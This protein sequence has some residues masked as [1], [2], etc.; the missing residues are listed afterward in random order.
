M[1]KVKNAEN[2]KILRCMLEERWLEILNRV[3]IE[4]SIQDAA[5]RNWLQ[6][7]VLLGVEDDKIYTIHL[8]GP[9]PTTTD[10]VKKKYGY[11]LQKAI[12]DVLGEFC[13][14]EFWRTELEYTISLLPSMLLK[15]LNYIKRLMLL[16]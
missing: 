10:Y 8:L 1:M 3:R 6:P 13:I 2:D 11:A 7:I 9:A 14:V 12:F 15:E 4:Q 16:M 5:Y